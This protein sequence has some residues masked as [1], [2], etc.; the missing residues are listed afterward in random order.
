M[1][2]HEPHYA[3]PGHYY[4]P[5]PSVEYVRANEE[6]IFR[7]PPQQL[8]GIDLKESEQLTLLSIFKELYKDQPFDSKNKH[9]LRYY[10]DNPAY[11]YSDAIFLHC[12]I[13]HLQPKQIIEV[14]SGYSS[15]AILDTN[16]T[17]CDGKI[18][19]TFIEPYPELLLS[20][21]KEPDKQSIKLLPMGLQQ[22]PLS[23]F[24]SLQANDILFIDSTHVGKIGSDVNYLFFEILPRLQP[25]VHVHFHDIFY[26]F[27]YPKEWI[28]EGRAWN[29]D[30]I[31]R[32][33]LSF[34]NTFEI[35]MFNTFLE[36]FHEEW[37]S[38]HMPLC[39]KNR[40]GSIWIKRR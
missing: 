40:G 33:F 5:I 29:E 4:S 2:G 34:N 12:M 17:H 25:G 23:N 38:Q 32:A 27:E 22:V 3:P 11:S 7:P 31:L 10:F 16:E 15:C 14:G 8:P 1:A 28:Y 21:I 37:F 35:V 18:Q 13:R 26:P 36:Y 19:C 20:L 9:G 30:Y 24:E 6:Y 39:L